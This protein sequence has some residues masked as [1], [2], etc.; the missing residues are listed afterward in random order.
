MQTYIIITEVTLEPYLFLLVAKNSNKSG[1][2]T[3]TNV[4]MV[5]R[6]AK[7]TKTS[8]SDI[9]VHSPLK[10]HGDVMPSKVGSPLKCS[11]QLERSGIVLKKN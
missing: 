10:A 11:L 4:D 5:K 7:P 8:L 2:Q 9:V 3:M 1:K 6:S